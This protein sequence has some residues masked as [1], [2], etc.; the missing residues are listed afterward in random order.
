MSQKYK[1][2]EEIVPEDFINLVAVA[3]KNGQFVAVTV[4]GTAT[5]KKYAEILRVVSENPSLFLDL[6]NHM[7]EDQSLVYAMFDIMNVRLKEIL[8]E[9]KK[10]RDAIR[11]AGAYVDEVNKFIKSRSKLIKKEI[12]TFDFDVA[13]EIGRVAQPEQE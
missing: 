1:K 10:S 11:Y 4:G 2:Y 3:E 9:E 6:P 7:L 13:K 5:D 8:I 12:P